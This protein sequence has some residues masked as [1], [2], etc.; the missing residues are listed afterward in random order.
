MGFTGGSGHVW[1][2]TDSGATWIDFTG[3]LPDSPVNAVVVYLSQVFVG[4]DVGVFASPTSA[5]SWTELGPNPNTNQPGFLPN[6]AVTALAVFASG[7][8]QLLR[9]STYGR[10][11]WQF[12][13]VLTPDYKLSV[14]NSPL[15]VFAG[16]TATFNG[17]AS[18][19]NG[20]TNSVTLSCIAG[21]TAPPSTCT[22]APSCAYASQQDAIQPHCWR[23]GWRLQLQCARGRSRHRS[24]HAQSSLGAPPG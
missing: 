9:A 20:Y 23:N 1:K 24:H 7:G 12:N 10:G 4:T 2:T 15:T 13:L 16:Q 6:V 18:A 14:S 17:T 11:I 19:T 8:Q 3:N 21:S 5:A 22:P